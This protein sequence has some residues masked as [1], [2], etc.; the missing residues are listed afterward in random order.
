MQVKIISCMFAFKV[1]FKN[2]RAKCRQLEKAAENKRK[3]TDKPKNT[4]Q[5]PPQP[6]SPPK[7][8]PIKKPSPSTSPYQLPSCSGNMWNSPPMAPNQN[9]Q[10]PSVLSSTSGPVFMP[11]PP[12]PPPYYRPN[13]D[14]SYMTSP[15]MHMNRVSEPHSQAHM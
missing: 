2:K 10:P 4:S 6:P 14:C 11:P 8:M 12:P 7:E 3:H 15:Y 13:S 5:P 9:Y 1:W